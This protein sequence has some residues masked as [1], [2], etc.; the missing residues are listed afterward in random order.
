MP[1]KS[2]I[3][4]FIGETVT[5]KVL[6][7]QLAA[8]NISQLKDNGGFEPLVEFV[9]ESFKVSW[10]GKDLQAIKSLDVITRDLKIPSRSGKDIA[11]FSKLFS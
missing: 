5:M 8:V 4:Q 7:R 1:S 6:S 2:D 11:N 3:E 10:R 9:R